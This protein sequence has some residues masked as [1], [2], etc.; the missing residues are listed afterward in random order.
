MLLLD[1]IIY[2]SQE[3]KVARDEKLVCLNMFIIF[4]K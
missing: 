4:K 3:N 1:Q 2:K